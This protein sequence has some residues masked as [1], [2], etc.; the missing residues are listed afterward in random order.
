M[1]AP[2]VETERLLLR[3][4][5]ARDADIVQREVS[6]V[7]IARMIRV[8][9]PYPEGG[10]AAWIATGAQPGRDFAVELRETEE[11]VGSVA[12][13]PHEEHRRAELGYWFA[14]SHWG[15][16]YATEA[17]RAIVDYG[18]RTLELNRVH[19]ECHGDNPASRRVLEKVG[20]TYEGSLRQHSFRLGPFADKLQFGDAPERMARLILAIAVAAVVAGTAAAS[21]SP[22]ALQLRYDRARDAEE[23]LIRQRERDPAR[24]RVLRAEIRRV[25]RLD[26]RPASWSRSRE[27]PALRVPRGS[28]RARAPLDYDAALAPRLA[29]L[30]RGFDGWAGLWVHDLRTGKTAGWNADA[31][32]PAASTVKLGVVAAALRSFR[33]RP[34]RSRGWYDLVQLTGWSS[35]LASNRLARELGYGAARDGLRRLGMTHS[36]YPGAYRPGTTVA[37][38]PKPPPHV[39]A[40]VTT[41]RDLGRALY[42]IH[43][44]A[45]GNRFVQ[46]QSGL[47]R[48]EARL[49][50][51]LLLDSSTAGDNAGLLRPF[52]PRATPVAQKNGW[53]SDTRIT[54]AI[55]YAAERPRIVVVAAYRPRLSLRKARA[56]GQKVVEA[57]TVE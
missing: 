57:V 24:L 16:G 23:R 41:P 12:I 6:R 48:R 38:A 8:P 29:A 22:E 53:I 30:G 18:F 17:V 55:V 46:R 5:E 31:A 32:F 35:N 2:R 34:E 43:A 33:P 45:A 54:A 42:R 50:L 15:R 44:A 4:F 21:P 19:A 47:S 20:M 39:H 52:L 14:L 3:P 27:V 51:A 26:S 1:G 11:L 36:T 40:R 7:E 49:A 56:L 10:A 28:M 13:N 37:D 25:E 9:H